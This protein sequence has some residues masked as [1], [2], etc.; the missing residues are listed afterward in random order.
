MLINRLNFAATPVRRPLV[1]ATLI[2]LLLGHLLPGGHRWQM[3]RILDAAGNPQTTFAIRADDPRLNVITSNIAKAKSSSPDLSTQYVITKWEMEV[4]EIYARDPRSKLPNPTSNTVKL[5]SFV[6]SSND[7]SRLAVESA[8]RSPTDWTQYWMT[9]QSGS[10]DKLA[11]LSTQSMESNIFQRL[12]LTE[13]KTGL[14]PVIIFAVQLILSVAGF[15][16]VGRWLSTATVHRLGLRAPLSIQ[17]PSDWT[18]RPLL[19]RIALRRFTRNQALE[20]IAISAC[21]LLA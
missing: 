20:V 15:L 18:G 13:T 1:Y 6:L 9:L 12:E 19:S 7:T 2:F 16:V 17:V 11:N 3:I 10:A 4:A 21:L 14:R 5:A 8:K